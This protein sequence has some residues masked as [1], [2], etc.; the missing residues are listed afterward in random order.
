[1]NFCTYS[2]R[3]T[4]LNWRNVPATATDNNLLF[5]QEKAAAEARQAGMGQV[6][7]L[8]PI[9]LFVGDMQI[10]PETMNIGVTPDGKKVVQFIQGPTTVTVLLEEPARKGLIKGLTGVQ[11]A[12]G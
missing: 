8:P 4:T 9:P 1:M 7:A 2:T 6:Q 10:R 11:L 3:D 5:K 12:G